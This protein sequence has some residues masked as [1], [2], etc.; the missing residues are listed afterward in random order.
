[1]VNATS[2]STDRLFAL[3]DLAGCF[4]FAE[5]ESL[6]L[7]AVGGGIVVLELLYVFLTLAFVLGG[8]APDAIA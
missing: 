8:A 1:S 4:P 2:E 5:V 3:D 7:A 6:V